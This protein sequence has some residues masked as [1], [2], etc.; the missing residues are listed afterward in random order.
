MLICI[1]GVV[2]LNHLIQVV[3]AQILHF[4]KT[5]YP[6]LITKLPNGNQA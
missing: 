2:K 4:K 3:Y 5:I 6:F 1:N